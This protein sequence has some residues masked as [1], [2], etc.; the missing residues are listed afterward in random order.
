MLTDL[1]LPF[2]FTLEVFT[3][4]HANCLVFERE[5]LRCTKQVCDYH[6]VNAEPTASSPHL[7]RASLGTRSSL[8]CPT[9][10]PPSDSW[11]P[12]ATPY[13]ITDVFEVLS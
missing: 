13:P 4:L 1:G 5:L 11:P 9:A 2:S 8:T 7:A 10:T 3:C 12:H 6:S